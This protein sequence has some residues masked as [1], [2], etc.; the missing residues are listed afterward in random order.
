MMRIMVFGIGRFYKKRKEYI[1]SNADIIAYVDNNESL[2]GKYM[3]DLP[4]IPPGD[5]GLFSYDKIL[6]MSLKANEMKKQLLNLG[7]DNGKIWY[8]EQFKSE[9]EHGNLKLYCGNRNNKKN[10]K[11][12]LVI[13]TCLNYN[14]GSLAAVYA[15]MAL[16]K[17]GFKVILSAPDGDH[18]FIREVNSEGVSVVLCPALPYIN[19]EELF[20]MQEFDVIL[21][22]VFQMALCACEISKIRPVLWWIHEYKAI[23]EE[24][25]IQFSEEIKLDIMSKINI[26][27][28]SSISQNNFNS[29]FPDRIKKIMAYGIPDKD[30]K[31]QNSIHKLTFAIIGSIEIRKAQDIFIQAVEL[32]SEQD[33]EKAQFW[34]IGY[35][36]TDSYGSNIKKCVE[37][38]SYVQILGK[39]SR[40]EIDKVYK[41]INVVVCPS[42]E[43]P[44]PIVMTEGMMYGKVCI[45]SDAN[46]TVDYI[47]DG[48]NGLICKS[49]DPIDLSKKMSWVINN[50]DKLH[51]MGWQARKTYEK[52]FTLEKFG[53]RLERALLEAIDQYKMFE[54]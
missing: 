23:F 41:V 33:K 39:L 12:I 40:D 19:K 46:G 28:V 52:Y 43:D 13:S 1:I 37:K 44:L 22:N 51:E 47:E 16:Q 15:V 53:D 6:L 35:M 31:D 3:D 18:N 9:I 48:R 38:E 34:I 49:G 30:C 10:G 11:K 20:W 54:N 26:Y 5:I 36:G 4:I 8:W 25:L 27:A 14:G 7:I 32:L 45:T 42:L 17:R 21:V 29:Y 50:K 2:Y 24:V